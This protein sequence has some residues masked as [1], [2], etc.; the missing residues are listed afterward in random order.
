MIG[1]AYLIATLHIDKKDLKIKIEPM[2]KYLML[3]LALG[4]V[5]AS[6]SNDDDG[7]IEPG[8]VDPDGSADVAAQNLMWKASNIWYFWFED[9]PDLADDRFST[10]E[11][12]TAFLET[13]S[14]PGKFFD[15]KIRFRDDR[16]TYFSDDFKQLTESQSGIARTN[17]VEF[18]LVAFSEGNDIFGYVKY[19]NP[20]TDASNK[21]IKRGDLFTGVDG[22]TLNRDNY[23]DLL[24]GENNTYTLNMAT[25]ENNSVAPSD[26]SVTLTKQEGVQKNPIFLEKVFELNGQKIGYLVYNGFVDEFDTQLNEVFGRFKAEGITD[27]VL[28]FRYNPGG[29]VLTTQ[30]ISSMIYDTDTDN[31]FTTSIVNDKVRQLIYGEDN[32]DGTRY[33]QDVINGAG[34][35]TLNLSKVYIIAINSSASASE[36]VI[37]GL[38]PYMDVIHVGDTTRGKNEFST[39]F[40]DDP[41]NSYLYAPSRENQINS[42]NRWAIQLLIGRSAN[43]D[44]FFEY[45][46]GLVPDVLLEEELDDLG[47]LGDLNEPLLA[48]T[49]Q[50]ITGVTSKKSF[51]SKMPISAE[52]TN[53]DMFQPMKDNMYLKG[54]PLQKENQN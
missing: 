31:V 27:L 50:E 54:V 9:V 18:G 11:E 48:R 45:T 51:V 12:Y 8:G 44:G 14:D 3:F 39:T 49:I 28:D 15:N 16:F 37:N 33:F 25:I 13:E 24:F 17:G 2:K 34:I 1:A 22:Q 36:L 52:L 30:R 7:V 4:F 47:V 21:D 35:N 46:N 43:S 42:D 19:I 29:S 32:P 38:A 53:S 5:L 26:K 41:G 6:C 23:R 20:N 10:T 40:V